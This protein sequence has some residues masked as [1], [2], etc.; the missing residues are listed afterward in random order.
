M[1][2]E[3]VFCD[4]VAGRRPAH[5]VTRTIFTIAFLDLRQD[6]RGTR[7]HP[8]RHIHDARELDDATVLL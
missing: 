6:H 2:E 1:N 3:C 8:R 5:L 4:I 7:R